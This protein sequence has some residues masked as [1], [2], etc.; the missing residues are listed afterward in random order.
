MNDSVSRFKYLVPFSVRVI[1][2]PYK[3]AEGKVYALFDDGVYVIHTHLNPVIHPHYD[4]PEKQA[5][6]AESEIERI[7]DG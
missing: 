1:G 7:S 6:A 2:G 3:G 5:Y 4:Q